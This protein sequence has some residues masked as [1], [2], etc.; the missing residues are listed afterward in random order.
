MGLAGSFGNYLINSVVAAS[1]SKD[2]FQNHPSQKPIHLLNDLVLEN[3]MS[4]EIIIDLFAGSGTTI[5]AC[6]NLN[7]KARAI[8]ISEKYC[9]VI[10]QRMED[11]FGI[12]GVRI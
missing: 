12:T 2:T 9:S 8:E 11:A 10:L 3:S 5:V 7:R 4:R 6:E 1:Y